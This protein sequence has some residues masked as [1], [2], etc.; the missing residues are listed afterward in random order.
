MLHA[1]VDDVDGDVGVHAA[2]AR[3]VRAVVEAALVE[4]AAAEA[5]KAAIAKGDDVAALES[6]VEGAETLEGIAF[7]KEG[8]EPP[9][10]LV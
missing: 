7:V 1:R 3:A 10:R 5:L 9:R 2:H 8:E 6:A 4:G